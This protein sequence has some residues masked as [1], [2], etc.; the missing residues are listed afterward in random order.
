MMQTTCFQFATKKNQRNDLQYFCCLEAQCHSRTLR[1]SYV[2]NENHSEG[3][4]LGSICSWKLQDFEDTQVDSSFS[5]A[6]FLSLSLT[7]K[8][9][10]NPP[11][12]PVQVL[13]N[14]AASQVQ[15]EETRD[16]CRGRDSTLAILLQ[17]NQFQQH[18]STLFQR[19]RE[20][21]ETLESSDRQ[22]SKVSNIV[23]REWMICMRRVMGRGVPKNG[24]CTSSCSE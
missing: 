7:L 23:C 6:L 20:F 4:K 17:P 8:N 10:Q 2:H 3:P 19:N 18:R 1:F 22:I 14:M 9:C 24:T 13:L 15:P 12:L 11:P 5:K 21:C 16:L